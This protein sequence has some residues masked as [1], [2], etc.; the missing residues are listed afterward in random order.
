MKYEIDNIYCVDAYKAIKD[1]P[2]KSIDCIYADIPYLYVK[3]GVGHSSLGTRL[4]N[5]N[6]ELSSFVD[7]INNTILNDFIRIS[8]MFNAFVWC[9]KMQISDLL[10]FAIVNKFNYDILV[11]CKTNPIPSTNNSWLQDIEYCIHMREKGVKLNHG[12][13][14]KHKY[15]VSSLNVNDKDKFIHPCCKPIPFI[16][17]HLLHATQENDIIFDPFIGSGTTAVAAKNLNRHYIG[18]EIEKKWCDI[19]KNRL[20]NILA[21]GQM[22][23]FT[24]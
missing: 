4:K 21:N 22:T 16:E 18:F 11:W 9:S 10:N 3:G 17:Q 7:G 15:Y 14:F 12:Y 5:R 6:K 24:M 1:I 2:D 19:A 20:D 8:K 23:M 13:E